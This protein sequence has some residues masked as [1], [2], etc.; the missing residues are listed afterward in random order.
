MVNQLLPAS[1]DQ[2]LS[3]YLKKVNNYP[4]LTEEEEFALA[5]KVFNHQDI[6]AAHTLV[7]S[8]LKLVVKIAIQMNHYKMSLMDLIAEGSIGLMHAVKKFNPYLG[9][10]LST[11]ATWWIKAFITEHIMKSWSLVKIGTTVAQKKLFF[12]LNKLK[13][14]ILNANNTNVLTDDDTKNIANQLSVSVDDVKE[15]DLRLSQISS[16]DDSISAEDDKT[17]FMDLLEDK[18]ANHELLVAN[19]QDSERKRQI[20]LSAL[21]TLNERE[22]EIIVARKLKED[23]I[24]LDDLSK[25]YNISRERVRQIETKAMEKLQKFC[26]EKI[27]Q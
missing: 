20:F 12:N 8:H 25:Q 22:K 17:T 4:S 16:L 6:A 26:L 27:A 24:T 7:T 19:M 10:R 5:E 15:M 9:N 3:K 11:Y 1:G 2:E 21:A 13:R 18:S 14:K 23:S